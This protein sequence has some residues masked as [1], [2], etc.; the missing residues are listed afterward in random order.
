MLSPGTQPISIS[1][2]YVSVFVKLLII[3]FCPGFRSESFLGIYAGKA[4]GDYSILFTNFENMANN[5]LSIHFFFSGVSPRLRH[6]KKLK[7]F[8]S[9]IFKSEGYKI[10]NLNY[11]F[12][13]DNTILK[14]NRQYLNH[15]FLT[16][17]IS[18]DLSDKPK[19]IVGE[20]YISTPRV[21]ENSRIFKT[22]FSSELHRVIFHGALHLCGYNDKTSHQKKE[23]K[24]K[25][26]FHLSLY[27]K[28][29]H[30]KY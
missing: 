29:F 7:Q 19:D 26:D 3:A 28:M 24:A 25:E 10:N 14:I 22:T 21:R 5:D 1:F 6:R 2:K 15:D 30:V 23:M 20:I 16:D 11:I 13:D 4:I 12:S 27:T 17:I 18:F 9:F 8:L